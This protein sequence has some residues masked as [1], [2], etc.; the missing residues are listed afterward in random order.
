M[1]ESLKQS[2]AKDLCFALLVFEW[3]RVFNKGF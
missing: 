2:V 1:P 3:L